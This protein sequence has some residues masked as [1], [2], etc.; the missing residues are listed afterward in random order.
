[1]FTQIL[2]DIGVHGA[3]VAE[4]YSLDAQEAL[5]LPPVYGLIFLF[6]WV[7]QDEG[8]E[9]A[10]LN[11]TVSDLSPTDS[12][13]SPWFASQV[14]DNACA[15][16]ALLNI[17]LNADDSQNSNQVDIGEYLRQFREFTADL[18]HVNRGLAL[19]SFDRLHSIHNKFARAADARD[20]DLQISRLA[21][22]ASRKKRR[23]KEDE[24]EEEASFHFIAFIPFEG[25]LWELDGLAGFPK[26]IG[27]SNNW[28]ENA[29]RRIQLR[30]ERYSSDEIR[31]NLMAVVKDSLYDLRRETRAQ[32]AILRTIEKRL[33]KISSN[34]QDLLSKQH[35]AQQYRESVD[36]DLALVLT[37]SENKEIQIISDESDDIALLKLHAAKREALANT[38]KQANS[39]ELS[40]LDQQVSVTL[41]RRLKTGTC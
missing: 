40:R 10:A 16:I 5:L 41:S 9:T 20:A 1:M 12:I 3:K 32:D 24:G 7:D 31:F 15:S 17:I 34:W 21:K 25:E 26:Q 23:R 6:R 19:A 22:E 33:S 36:M 4:L 14:T 35:L 13:Q 39:E 11:D 29:I 30:I 37:D 28:I 2:Q 18:N 38:I 8:E 27:N